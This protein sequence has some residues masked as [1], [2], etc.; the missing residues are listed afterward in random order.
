MDDLTY[1]PI[2][3]G[4]PTET[5]DKLMSLFSFSSEGDGAY[6]TDIASRYLQLVV[7]L[8]Y[9]AGVPREIKTIAK[10]TN[11]K[12]M[13]E[14]F[15]E[16]SN[17]VEIVDEVEIEEE[18]AVGNNN[19]L[20]L[21]EDDLSDFFAPAEPKTGRIKKTVIEKRRRSVT[22]LQQGMQQIKNILDDEFPE[23]IVE[24]CLTR[25]KMQLGELLESD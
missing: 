14:F 10:L 4:T 22:K 16:H 13:N 17:E 3:N 5:R 9:E 8:I 18:V 11:V 15:K 12:H 1:N 2:K 20:M 23:E 24:G 25:L 21:P 7:K 6:Y 19:A